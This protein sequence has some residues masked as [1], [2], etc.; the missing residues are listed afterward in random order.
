MLLKKEGLPEFDLL[1]DW[2]AHY[3]E[4]EDIVKR[5][6][7]LKKAID[8]N[9][10]PAHD[11]YRMKLLNKRFFSKSKKKSSDSFMLA[12]IMIKASAA[13]SNSFSIPKQIQELENNL[14]DLCLYGFTP[15]NEAEQQVLEEE[16]S[17]FGRCHLIS[18]SKSRNYCSTVFNMV[19]LQDDVIAR[20]IAAEINLVT[21]TYP[22]KFGLEAYLAPLRRIMI[23]TFCQMIE[24]GKSYWDI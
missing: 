10:D 17:N 15:E 8:Q 20:K 1:I 19:S 13:A 5:K 12:W 2:P 11:C 21:L 24:N 14:R 16:W 23:L 22:S 18:C 4:I 3:Y 7:Y 9:L 6:K